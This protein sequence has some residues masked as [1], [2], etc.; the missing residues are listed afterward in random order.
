MRPRT[1][2]A[3]KT[4]LLVVVALVSQPSFAYADDIIVMTSGA[5]A[6]AHLQL[7]P[8]FEKMTKNKI[9][10]AATSTGVGAEAIPNRVQ[11]GEAV[12][13]IILAAEAIDE[14]IKNG[15]VVAG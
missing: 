11:R 5:F 2:L 9:V 7:S 14:L 6:E 3:W 10:T 12:D 8:V 13:V 4:V 1:A 15:G